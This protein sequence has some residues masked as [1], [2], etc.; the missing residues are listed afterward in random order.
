MRVGMRAYYLVV[1]S[2]FSEYVGGITFRVWRTFLCP[3]PHTG[4]LPSHHTTASRP[5]LAML[6]FAM[7]PATAFWRRVRTRTLTPAILFASPS[8]HPFYPVTPH[9]RYNTLV[10]TYPRLPGRCCLTLPPGTAP[11]LARIYLVCSTGRRAYPTRYTCLPIVVI[12]T[13]AYLPPR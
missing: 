4:A 5:A 2:V 1:A 3:L 6:Y 12:Q 10:S 9:H 8:A 11:Q 13:A 7:R